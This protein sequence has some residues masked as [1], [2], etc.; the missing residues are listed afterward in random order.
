MGSHEAGFS[1]T[2]GRTNVTTQENGF[3]V[4]RVQAEQKVLLRKMGSK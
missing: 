3:K 4:G 1:V 2:T